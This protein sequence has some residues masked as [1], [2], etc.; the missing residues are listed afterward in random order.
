M[1]L[2]EHSGVNKDLVLAATIPHLNKAI[3]QT[4]AALRRE[5]CDI[6]LPKDK[7]IYEVGRNIEFEMR[8]K[9]GESEKTFRAVLEGIS[10]ISQ[11]YFA[12]GQR[13]AGCGAATKLIVE[14]QKAGIDD[15]EF[16]AR[17]LMPTSEA[18]RPE[19]LWAEFLRLA[20]EMIALFRAEA[21]RTD[22]YTA[23]IDVE[24]RP[25]EIEAAL[26]HRTHMSASHEAQ[27][28]DPVGLSTGA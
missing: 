20:P 28:R 26:R 22:D 17:H 23:E 1:H 24:L 9:L 14:L 13:T 5:I 2:E 4:I 3:H 8:S 6:P 16:K 18:D 12:I 10:I 11:A 15:A 19:A 7:K 27:A 25:A 21:E